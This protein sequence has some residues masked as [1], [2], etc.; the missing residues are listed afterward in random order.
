MLTRDI[1]GVRLG[2][3]LIVPA[4]LTIAAIVLFLGRL[5]L[6]AHRRPAV[7]GADALVGQQARTRTAVSPA[8]GLVDVR[9]EIWRATSDTPI[10]AGRV[11]R[12]RALN[13]LTLTVE[14]EETP[15]REGDTAWKA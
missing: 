7:T 1:P 2:L 9:G 12:I 4:V 5:A 11:V 3:S 14:A 10:D 8:T 13:G 6:V 15:T